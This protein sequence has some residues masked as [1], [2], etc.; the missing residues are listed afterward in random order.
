MEQKQKKRLNDIALQK[1]R[2]IGESAKRQ[3]YEGNTTTPDS[4][5][6]HEEA[7]RKQLMDE[8]IQHSTPS[9]GPTIKVLTNVQGIL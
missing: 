7:I 3:L 2:E 4:L 9:D 5:L 6:H 1:E 8:M